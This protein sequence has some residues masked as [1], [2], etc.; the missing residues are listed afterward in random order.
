MSLARVD[1]APKVA[2]IFIGT[3]FQQVLVIANTVRKVDPS[4]IEAAQTLGARGWRLVRRVVIP[5]SISDIY[6]DMRIL[7]EMRGDTLPRMVDGRP[8]KNSP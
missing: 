6:T 1:D 3:F 2:L 4:L 5:A 8:T 7:L